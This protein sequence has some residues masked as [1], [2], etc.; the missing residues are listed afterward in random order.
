M[1]NELLEYF[2]NLLLRIF[3]IFI[4]PKRDQVLFIRKSFSGSNI[5]PVYSRISSLRS[6]ID[7][8][9]I[10]YNGRNI[11]SVFLSVKNFFII[12]NSKLIVT[13]HGSVFKT[14]KNFTLEL[15]HAFP[16]KKDGLY[17]PKPNL[18]LFHKYTDFILSYSEFGTLLFNA[19]I[20]IPINKY[21]EF[22]SPRNDYFFN[23]E[24]NPLPRKFAKIIIYTPTY[25][26]GG[27]TDEDSFQIFPNSDFSLDRF[28]SYLKSNNFLFIWKSHPNEEHKILSKFNEISTSNIMMLSDDKLRQ[29]NKDLYQI[30]PFTDLLITDYSSIYIDYLLLKK[31]MIFTPFD[32]EEYDKIRGELLTPYSYWHPGPICRSQ[33]A[34]EI[35][36]KK[37]LTNKNYYSKERNQLTTLFHKYADGNS[38]DRVAKFILSKIE[39]T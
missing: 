26:E 12:L 4:R 24:E 35:E 16:T 39:F 13:T 5:T 8:K 23:P 38:S 7:L 20:G 36:I 29:Y 34:L 11:S 14:R 27:I 2:Y 25:R 32:Q 17:L 37:C 1:K 18:S 30:L 10:D 15:W 33:D 31:P 28:C 21:L 9:L 19:R 6:Y 3:S 22:G